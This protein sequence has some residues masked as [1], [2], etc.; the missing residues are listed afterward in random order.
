MGHDAWGAAAN[1]GGRRGKKEVSK[2]LVSRSAVVGAVMLIVALA[3]QVRPGS[4]GVGTAESPAAIVVEADLS[5]V[6]SLYLQ[7][8]ENPRAID[9]GLAEIE[10][11][12]AENG[13]RPGSW[14]AT[15]L[16]AYR[17]ALTTRRAK[18]A[19]WP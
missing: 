5:L 6:R 14:E 17:G 4:E 11:I 13:T 8:V 12:S 15:T 2:G 9:R 10:R 7:A 16:T 18:H 1:A 3:G 19:L